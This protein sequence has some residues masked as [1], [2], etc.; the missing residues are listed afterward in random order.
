MG[1]IDER[2]DKR[3]LENNAGRGTPISDKGSN[4]AQQRRVDPMQTLDEDQPSSSDDELNP[5][6]VLIN[7]KNRPIAKGLLVTDDHKRI[8]HGRTVAPNERKVYVQQVI[9]PREPPLH[10]DFEEAITEGTWTTW[11]KDKLVR[12]WG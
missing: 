4:S 5:V 12:H 11:P 7:R 9:D 1:A 3:M 8:C 10:P 2:I 6:V